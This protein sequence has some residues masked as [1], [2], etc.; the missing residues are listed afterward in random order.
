[1]KPFME[2][3]GTDWVWIRPQV[4]RRLYELRSGDEVLATIE[5]RALFN[6]A[7]IAT[8]SQGRSLLRHAGLLRGKVL[9]SSED[10]TGIRLTFKPGWFG[11]GVAHSAGGLEWHWKR[12]DFWGRSW[13]FEDLS[14]NPVLSFVRRPSWFRA[15]VSVEPSEYARS[16]S[17]LS[18]LAL[19]GFYLLL[20]MQRQAH[21]S[22]R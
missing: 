9:L 3:F 18:D 19:L 15:S 10:A 4:F 8:S 12:V 16:L 21:V 22:A 11:A 6:S 7:A 13:R 20:L 17:E 14:G 1:M 2:S 5:S